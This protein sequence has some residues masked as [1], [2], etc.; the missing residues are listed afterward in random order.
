MLTILSLAPLAGPGVDLLRALGDLKIDAWNDH[1]PIQLHSA[2][3]LVERLQGVAVLIVEADHISA[4]VL[5]KSELKYLGV[6][7][8]DPNNVDS[9]YR[10]TVEGQVAVSGTPSATQRWFE[11]TVVVTVSDGRLTVTNGSGA[12]NNKINYL[13]VI[14]A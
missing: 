8:G 7:R 12:V 14:A 2:E 1:V 6:C 5:E 9:T 10:L 11:G 4:E 3:Q 13:D